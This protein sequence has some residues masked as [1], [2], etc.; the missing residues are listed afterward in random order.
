MKEQYYKWYSPALSLETKMLVFGETGYPIVIFP[1][2]MGKFYQNKDF[3]LINAVR[4]F[5]EQ[6]MIKIYCVDSVDEF[7]LYNKSIAPADR[8]RNHIFYDNFLFNE[9]VPRIQQD[10]GVAKIAFA[11]C[12][13]GAYHATN[14]GF[15]H[16][17]VCSFIINMGGAFDI[18]DRLDGYYDLNVYYNNPVDFVPDLQNPAIYQLGVILGV[19][20]HDFCLDANIH[21]A[22]I[23]QQKGI[24]HWLD[25]RA[26]ATHDWPVWRAMF[27]EYVG[28]LLNKISTQ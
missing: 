18:R 12:S 24:S 10:C 6:G 20:E 15:K 14:F 8:I 16:P 13:F 23:L 22:G 21:F 17:E 28:Q 3:H 19:G 9:L 2:S 11:G 1:T 25:I 7:S 4:W 26:G 5:I 27:P